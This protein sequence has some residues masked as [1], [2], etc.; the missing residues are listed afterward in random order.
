M[1]RFSKDPQF[2]DYHSIYSP[3]PVDEMLKMGAIQEDRA[4]KALEAEGELTGLRAS[5]LN[6]PGH[7]GYAK[8]VLTPFDEQIANVANMDPTDPN[9]VR[10]V[11]RIKGA[12]TRNPDVKNILTSKD[13]Y[14]KRWS[15]IMNDPKNQGGYYDMQGITD[16]YGKFQENELPYDVLNFTPPTGYIDRVNKYL[17]EVPIQES[18]WASDGEIKVDAKGNKIFVQDAGTRV[19]RDD[20][21]FAPGIAGLTSALVDPNDPDYRFMKLDWERKHGAGSFTPQNINKWV[22]ELSKHHIVDYN[23]LR[24]SSQFIRESAASQAEEVKP[25]ALPQFQMNQTGDNYPAEEVTGAMFMGDKGLS[26]PYLGRSSRTMK[27]SIGVDGRYMLGSRKTYIV[28][29]DADDSGIDYGGALTQQKP[30]YNA[31]VVDNIVGYKII[32]APDGSLPEGSFWDTGQGSKVG[33]LVT[34]GNYG[35]VG[36]T[37]IK[38]TPEKDKKGNY[39]IMTGPD[40]KQKIFVQPVALRVLSGST[41]PEK[42]AVDSENLFLE[43][44]PRKESMEANGGLN[45]SNE[46]PISIINN[47]IVKDI[48]EDAYNRYVM[49]WTALKEDGSYVHPEIVQVIK[50]YNELSQIAEQPG[51][52]PTDED[53]KIIE[54]MNKH[55]IEPQEYRQDV[56]P[57][58]I[59]P[60]TEITS[61]NFLGSQTD[62]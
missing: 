17:G 45:W 24:K 40:K 34:V 47:K 51:Y 56:V 43:E 42:D 38:R 14:D 39:F 21:D 28:G 59:T 2:H 11:R 20:K 16:T 33:N 49:P 9:M 6:A 50:A 57:G 12:L 22:T 32:G 61:K 52:V 58:I 46:K 30:L 4:N 55:V 3:F 1:N 44:V 54:L 19:H 8:R 53:Y 31:K 29:D 15:Q 60:K 41:S 62:R 35:S 36:E 25:I 26:I 23:K 5:I 18:D 37:D 7:S 10:E 27:Q 13:T 48:D